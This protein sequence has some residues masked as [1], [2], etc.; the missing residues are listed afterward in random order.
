MES[1]RPL[2][3]SLE[4]ALAQTLGTLRDVIEACPP[5]A[6]TCDDFGVAFWQHAY[7]ALI[8]V[9]FWMR[10]DLS[11][12]F[13]F[14]PFHNADDLKPNAAPAIARSDIMAFLEQTEGDIISVF[15][16]MTDDRLVE[17]TTFNG[18]PFSWADRILG[19]IQHVQHHAALMKVMLRRNTGVT[20]IC[21]GIGA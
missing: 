12:P 20:T 7:H 18:Q 17:V 21:R 13:E 6:W 11:Q 19:Q 8:G 1:A 14:P 15:D 3:G 5:D 2:T 9:P 4:Q 10:D 16:T